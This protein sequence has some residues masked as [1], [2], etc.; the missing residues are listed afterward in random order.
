MGNLSERLITEMYGSQKASW[1]FEANYP[2]I[3][4]D[5]KS[6]LFRWFLNTKNLQP[7]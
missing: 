7:C 5:G 6:S 2:I 3:G 4:A 1:D